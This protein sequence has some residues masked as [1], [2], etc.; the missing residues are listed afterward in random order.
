MKYSL[1]FD[2]W[3]ILNNRLDLLLR[4]KESYPQLKVSL[5]TIPYDIAYENDVSARL[6]REKT[7]AEVK[8]HLSWM[9]II[10]HGLIHV[11]REFEKCTYETM[12]EHIF[13]AIEEAFSKDG[14]PYEKGFKAPYWL[15]NEGV[16]RALDEE[17]WWGAIDRNQNMLKTKR[18]YQYSHSIHEAYYTAIN[19]DTIKLHG[20]ITGSIYN[21][22]E[23]CFS[24]LFK[25]D[26]NAE[27]VFVSELLEERE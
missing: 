3:S 24:N 14:I 25:M 20:H 17:G 16:V 15:W 26:T 18:Y 6:L 27:F 1:D 19:R 7:V 4:L 9:Q 8:K 12:K 22:F 21:S 13:P 10:P 11:P 23:R 2:D 5:F